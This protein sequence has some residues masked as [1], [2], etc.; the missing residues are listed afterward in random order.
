V[1]LRVIL[2]AIVSAAYS[3]KNI[4]GHVGSTAL[5][6][7]IITSTAHAGSSPVT[8]SEVRVLFEGNIKPVSLRHLPAPDSIDDIRPNL[9]NISLQQSSQSNDAH[10]VLAGST[11]LLFHPGQTRIFEFS[12]P[13]REAGDA[14]A[15]SAT[16]SIAEKLFDV[17]FIQIFANNI[18]SGKWWHR[19]ETVTRSSRLGSL[20]PS[21]LKVLPKPPK[22]EMR[23]LRFEEVPYYTDEKITLH[24]ELSNDEEDEAEA[25]LEVRILAGSQEPPELTWETPQAE[26]DGDREGLPGHYIGRLHSSAKT[27]QS[28][29]L[30][31]SHDAVDYVL[32]VKVLYHLLADKETP[33]S[34]TLTVNLPI[35]APFESQYDF[36]PRVHPDRWPSYFQLQGAIT[37]KDEAIVHAQGIAQKWC[38]TA[39]LLSFATKK[40]ILEDASVQVL[41]VNGGATCNIESENGKS[42]FPLEIGTSEEEEAK[43]I[44]DVQKLTL[45]DRRSATLDLE[46]T[47]RWRRLGD[48]T[49]VNTTSVPIPRLLV[50]STEPR[51]LAS[52]IYSTIVPFL[53]HLDFTLENPTMHLLTF[54]LT[55]EANEDFAFSGSKL[56]SLQL[57]PISRHT[58]RFNLL[59]TARGAW[60]Q[61]Q[62]RVVDRYFN[63][64]L[65]VSATEGMRMDKKGILVWVEPDETSGPRESLDD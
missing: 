24:V 65:R 58:V 8:L 13:L 31:A 18:P 61:P 19:T 39:R 51:V 14:T 56:S 59:P 50:P 12:V 23:F 20:T 3:F 62:L 49:T 10:S 40:V 29:R 63:K 7:L 21:A 1:R 44:L 60:I 64:T 9:L 30:Q 25:S 2:I 46:L 43:F 53:I 38:L 48:G 27:V 36:S 34:K 32:E 37:N 4:E 52:V 6:Q 33:I 28:F 17:D 26:F 5:S 35:R 42:R 41:G 16:L 54:S 15:V 47:I 11:N 22:I 45:E 55:M 57:L